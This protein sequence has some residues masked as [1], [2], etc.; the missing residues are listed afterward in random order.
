MLPMTAW[1]RILPFA[2]S[3]TNSPHCI[4]ILQCDRQESATEAGI[5]RLQKILHNAAV[6]DQGDDTH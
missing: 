5:R 4:T 3:W 2:V 1:G 6:I